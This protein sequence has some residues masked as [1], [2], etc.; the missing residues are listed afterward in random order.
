MQPKMQMSIA[1]KKDEIIQESKAL[2]RLSAALGSICD[3]TE[4]NK[5]IQTGPN[6]TVNKLC[7]QLVRDVTA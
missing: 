5:I 3:P 2:G 1:F 7:K 6:N 4:A